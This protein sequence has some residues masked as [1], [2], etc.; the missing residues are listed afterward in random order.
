MFPKPSLNI[1]P[2]EIVTRPNLQ[3]EDGVYSL[4]DILQKYP[5][6]RV[7]Q[8]AYTLNDDIS[9]ENF[10]FLQPLLLYQ[11]RVCNKVTATSLNT[12][13]QTGN[14]VEVG[15]PL[16]IPEDYKGWF[17]VTLKPHVQSVFHYCRVRTLAS[18]NCDTILIGGEHD[19][20]ALQVYR[21]GDLPRPRVL[22]PGDVLKVGNVHVTTTKVKKSLFMKSVSKEEKFLRCMDYAD[23]E[24]LLPFEATGVFYPL[25]S[26]KKEFPIMLV[27]DIIADIELPCIV[28]LVYGRVPVTPCIFTGVMK[29]EECHKEPSVIVSSVFN[30]K[31]VLLEIPVTIPLMFRVAKNDSLLVDSGGYNNALRQCREDMETYMRNIK[32]SQGESAGVQTPNKSQPSFPKV[33]TSAHPKT[34]THSIPPEVPA[35]AKLACGRTY[36]RQSETS[37]S[38]PSVDLFSTGRSSSSASILASPISD[39]DY[40]PMWI[41]KHTPRSSTSEHSG[42]SHPQIA[43]QNSITISTSNG[44]MTVPMNPCDPEVL[45]RQ[46]VISLVDKINLWQRMNGFI[47]DSEDS[48]SIPEMKASFTYSEAGELKDWDAA[49]SHRDAAKGLSIKGEGYQSGKSF[50]YG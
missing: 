32:V 16:L 13:P 18:S 37:E 28:K 8:C 42:I 20:N 1:R 49:V 29:L 36:D 2:Q 12:D 48:A 35:S 45:D 25:K 31:N 47:S 39:G 30:L 50:P 27:K 23:R 40:T 10:D 22:Y 43:K 4:E 17:A 26:G 9:R 34:T 7:V 33:P 41:G 14:T 21:E 15:S 24:L 46:Q 19:V 3:W 44:Y 6:P 11:K 38:L 5:L